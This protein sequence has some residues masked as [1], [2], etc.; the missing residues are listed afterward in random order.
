MHLR[1]LSEWKHFDNMWRH[2]SD[3]SLQDNQ[4]PLFTPVLTFTSARS[5]VLVLELAMIAGRRFSYSFLMHVPYSLHLQGFQQTGMH[6]GEL[7]A[8]PSDLGVAVGRSRLPGL[9]FCTSCPELQEL[10]LQ[11]PLG[12]FYIHLVSLLHTSHIA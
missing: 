2:A 12:S 7:L 1:D 4:V 11:T 6:I 10:I 8:N 9:A 3:L 5:F